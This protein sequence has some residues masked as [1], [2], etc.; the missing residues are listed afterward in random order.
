MT[1]GR[2]ERRAGR[3]R[4]TRFG[5]TAVASASDSPAWTKLGAKRR[6]KSGGEAGIRTL[7][8]TLRSYNGLANRRLQ[9]LGHL[10]VRGFPKDLRIRLARIDYCRASVP[11]SMPK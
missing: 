11:T 6:A 5:A 2:I 3:L 8:T 9:P 10:T 1:W 4:A 7:G